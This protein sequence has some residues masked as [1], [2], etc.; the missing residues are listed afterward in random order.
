MT[1]LYPSKSLLNLLIDDEGDRADDDVKDISSP[2]VV[3]FFI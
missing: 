2:S 3:I 1:H